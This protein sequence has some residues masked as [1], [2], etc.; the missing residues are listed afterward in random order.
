L[1]LKETKCV[2]NKYLIISFIL[3]DLEKEENPQWKL[4][5]GSKIQGKQQGL[6]VLQTQKNWNEYF[7]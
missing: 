1:L 3:I 5:A 4:V 7:G 2:N 6:V